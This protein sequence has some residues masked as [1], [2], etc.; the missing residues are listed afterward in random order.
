VQWQESPDGKAWSDISGANAIP[1]T[2]TASFSQNG[3][4]YRVIFSNTL[5]SVTSNPAILTVQQP[6]AIS[7]QPQNATVNAGETVTFSAA[8]SG[9]PAP[10]VQWQQSLDLGATWIDI[11]GAT[12]PSYSFIASYSM[13]G[14]E[15]RAIF[16]NSLGSATTD[17]AVLTVNEVTGTASISGLVFNDLN[18][19]KVKD[20]GEAGLSGW[21]VQL[22]DAGGEWI[23]D[24]S[25]DGGGSY[26]YT[27][28]DLSAGVFRARL[29]QPLPGGYVQTTQD[30]D[31]IT[32]ANGQTVTGVNFGA[33]ISADLSVS[34]EASTSG[35]TITYTII[36]T[37]DGPADAAA[38][39]LKTTL[40]RY[41]SYVSYTSTQGTCSSGKGSV[42]CS[43]GTLAS[44]QSATI[45]LTVNRTS[46]RYAIVNTA[47]VSSSTFDIDKSDNSMT[48]T[49]P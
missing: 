32:L 30:P 37:N 45:T 16:T 46:T 47:T 10:T 26:N 6:P 8:A 41:T 34:M 36:V 28:S 9:S 2:F 49:V 29:A 17:P 25:T 35:S 18:G 48:V 1:Y 13:N 12:S 33:V 15:Y 27:F 39:S 7:Q 43:L 31:D 20:T 23:A 21:T 22:F 4:Q 19:N 3:Y 14:Y 44:G 24:V 11:S 40:S 42:T 38:V 5:G